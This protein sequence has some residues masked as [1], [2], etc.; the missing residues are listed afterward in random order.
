MV[1][2]LFFFLA[3]RTLCFGCHHAA[4]HCAHTF[5]SFLY[6]ARIYIAVTAAT[7][8]TH[9]AYAPFRLPG[10]RLPILRTP[11]HYRGVRTPAAHR[12]LS[13]HTHHTALVRLHTACHTHSP[14]HVL[15]GVLS[16]PRHAGHPGTTP[17]GYA[18][19]TWLRSG[20]LLP[21]FSGCHYTL[22]AV[23]TL[24]VTTS[25]HGLSPGFGLVRTTT[26]LVFSAYYLG[27][28]P[29]CL[30]WTH[31][32]LSPRT[33]R[34]C[35]APRCIRRCVANL[36]GRQFLCAWTPN[37]TRITFPGRLPGLPT[38]LCQHSSCIFT[39]RLFFS[40]LWLPC[41][42]RL[43]TPLLFTPARLGLCRIRRTRFLELM[44]L[45]LRHKCARAFCAVAV[46]RFL[47]RCAA[48][49]GHRSRFR[50]TALAFVLHICVAR[51]TARTP[52]FCRSHA[53]FCARLHSWFHTTFTARSAA[54]LFTLPTRWFV[55][56]ARAQ[57][58]AHHHLDVQD[59]T[60]HKHIF[61]H[62]HLPLHTAHLRT[63]FCWF[64][65]LY[66]KHIHA[67]A[68]TR[69]LRTALH[70]ST[71]LPGHYTFHLSSPFHRLAD[72]AGSYYFS[73]SY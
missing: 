42:V 58:T 25:P 46:A 54:A 44:A 47:P 37:Y 32:L 34:I 17:P 43:L 35:C 45:R 66:L 68:C 5:G 13:L 14:A 48:R 57:H 38:C 1:W 10:L 2:T 18:H 3:S 26:F 23:L 36:R 24:P 59:S 63:P 30:F 29:G 4:A 12:H 19:H 8:D 6:T 60:A 11:P 62:S 51:H 27:Y 39:F 28:T 41:A 40:L 15:H 61:A 22:V 55:T 56:N 20:S 50:C 67:S 31:L 70:H 16:P 7:M 64:T 53:H 73:F 9:T 21:T 69:C 49:H 33:R 71:L 52:S 72:H 65:T